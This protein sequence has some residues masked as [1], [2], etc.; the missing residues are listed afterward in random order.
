MCGYKKQIF[1]MN[2]CLS[3]NTRGFPLVSSIRE[4]WV[5]TNICVPLLHPQ[6]YLVML[7]VMVY[8]CHNWVEMLVA[9]LFWKFAGTLRTS[10]QG[11]LIQTR[12]A[13][14]LLGLASHVHDDFSNRNLP[15]AYDGVDDDTVL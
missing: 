5:T 15:I 12:S 13:Q 9:S 3:L 14:G 6:G 2:C 1:S 10:P 4:L 11:R 8:R 7:V